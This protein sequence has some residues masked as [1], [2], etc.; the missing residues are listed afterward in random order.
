MLRLRCTYNVEHGRKQDSYL[1]EFTCASLPQ[2]ILGC[3]YNENSGVEK[4]R[5][6]KRNKTKFSIAA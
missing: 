3:L 1:P 5:Y 2:E 4:T 6:M